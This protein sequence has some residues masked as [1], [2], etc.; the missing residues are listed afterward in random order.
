MS[1]ERLFQVMPRYFSLVRRERPGSG[2]TV[3]REQP[4]SGATVRRERPGSGA[5]V[6]RERPGSLRPYR[7][8]EAVG[9][10]PLA[11]LSGSVL[12]SGT[13]SEGLD[14]LPD[15]SV[16]TVVT[17]PPHWS[18]HGYETDSQTALSY[19]LANYVKGIVEV[20]DEVRR[21]LADDGT[22]WLSISDGYMSGNRLRLLPDRDNLVRMMREW[23]PMSEGL[24]PENL[25][26]VPWRLALAL[27]D[28]G[29][30]LRSE[31]VWSKPYDH[32]ESVRDRPAKV[33]GTVFMLSK[34]RDCYYNADAVREPGG[35]RLSTVW[36][37]HAEPRDIRTDLCRHD[38]SVADEYTTAM[39]MTLAR[40]CVMATSEP[41]DAV[42]DPYAGS[43]TALL[44]AHGLN[45]RWVGIEVN[46]AFVDLIEH[47]LAL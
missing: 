46:P 22:A 35:S 7:R 20:F 16:R 4:G 39:P 26:G 43:G 17:T 15:R 42:L 34:S 30:W 1:E 19:A 24:K 31:V 9:G 45:R 12:I 41:G 13:A 3:R 18:K 29:W 38:H 5:T 40:W 47:R 32:S 36:D 2:A 11:E 33:H 27:Q 23:K 21:V 37:I 14:M 25:I 28:A 10:E 8:I 6:R 44:A